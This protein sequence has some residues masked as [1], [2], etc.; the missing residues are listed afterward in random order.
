VF[1]AY[2]RETGEKLAIKV[3]GDTV[4]GSSLVRRFGQE[5]EIGERVQ[6]LRI[7][8]ILDSGIADGHPWYSM[9]RVIGPSLRDRLKDERQL[10]FEEAFRITTEV[11]E[12][13]DF[14][15]AQGVVHRDVKP[16]NILLGPR[17]AMLT[18]FGIARKISPAP[19]DPTFTS[20]GI[21]VG[22]VPY[23]SPEQA[24]ASKDV[25][26]RSDVYSLACV[27][28]EMLGG[29]PPFTGATPQA[30][31]AQH[32]SEKPRSLRVVRPGIPRG[33]DAAILKALSKV[34]ADRFATAGEFAKALATAD[35]SETWED[36]DEFVPWYRQMRVKVAAAAVVVTVGV[37]VM[38][39][40]E[41]ILD[42]AM[43]AVVSADTTAAAIAVTE[44][45]RSSIASWRDLSVASSFAVSDA[46]TKRADRDSDSQRA[47]RAAMTLGAGTYILTRVEL[48]GDSIGVYAAMMDTKSDSLRSEGRARF[49]STSGPPSAHLGPIVDSLLFRSSYPKLIRPE[50]APGTTSYAARLAYLNGQIA[51]EDGRFARADSLFFAAT[52]SDPNYPQALTWLA[53]VRWWMRRGDAPW[54][55]AAQQAARAASERRVLAPSDSATASAILAMSTS[56]DPSEC[57]QWERQ[58]THGSNDFLAWYSLAICLRRDSVVLRDRRS[59]TGWRFRTSRQSAIRAYERAFRLRPSLIRGLGR[60]AL[61][62][63]KQLYVTSAGLAATGARQKPDTGGFRAYPEWEANSLAFYPA[64]SAIALA[65]PGSPT[66]GTAVRRGR[67]RLSVI[68]SLWRS[69]FLESAEAAE[70]VAS[71]LELLGN[72]TA[73]DT[74]RLAARLAS[75]RADSARLEAFAVLM[76]IKYAIPSNTRDIREAVERAT[77]LLSSNPPSAGVEPRALGALAALLGRANLAAGYANTGGMGASSPAVAQSGP[78]LVAFAALTGPSD[79][80]RALEARFVAAVASLPA[81][82]ARPESIR[83]HARAAS[84]SF[85]VHQMSIL[86]ERSLPGAAG[87]VAAAAAGDSAS[88]AASVA[89]LAVIRRVLGASELTVDA[90]LPE[91]AALIATRD[92]LGAMRWLSPTLDALAQSTT[93]DHAQIPRAAALVRAMATRAELEYAGG[94]ADE[95][96][97]WA[98]AVAQIWAGADPFLQPVVRRMRFVAGY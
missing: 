50:R 60:G 78:A 28:Y 39:Q 47:R 35:L 94:R 27:V 66:L 88:V 23:M 2:D 86:K 91:T 63:L 96:R 77:R 24:A 19:D 34:P 22:T 97:R 90:L 45:L 59:K 98:S 1:A 56:R 10:S 79:S 8:P 70:A 58:T 20:T 85:P 30:V 87:L 40:D 7:V 65:G 51:L 15:H 73:L 25:G 84:L 14:A 46:V 41:P 69:E 62:D 48:L 13:L 17:G 21:A 16:G 67:E 18:D 55:A 71:S 57:S 3:L 83:W 5:V 12:A 37:W 43:I 6:H 74:M 33:V 82:Q 53:V 89:R 49:S 38:S 95:A 9:P 44:A 80:L 75:N 42:P 61:D 36:G 52:R 29:E 4:A 54:D 11:A 64:P 92:T 76:Q 31:M 68:A 72:A 26:P 32:A 81:E 93:T